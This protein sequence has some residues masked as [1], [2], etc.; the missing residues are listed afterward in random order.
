METKSIWSNRKKKSL[1]LDGRFTAYKHCPRKIGRALP[2]SMFLSDS[3]RV[4]FS[5]LMSEDAI[6]CV[7]VMIPSFSLLGNENSLKIFLRHS[8]KIK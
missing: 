4:F 2:K 1:Y 7:A 5:E 3:S 8:N 6:V